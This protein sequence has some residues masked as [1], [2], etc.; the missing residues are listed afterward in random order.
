MI[1]Y[2]FKKIF[3]DVEGKRRAGG[4]LSPIVERRVD[5]TTRS[6]DD[7]E[8]KRRRYQTITRYQNVFALDFIG[9][10]DGGGGEW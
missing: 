7:A 8:R 3:C 5:G 9:A 2:V 1:S 10:E 6:A 4:R